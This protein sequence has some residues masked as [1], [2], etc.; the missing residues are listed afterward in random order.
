MITATVDATG[1]VTGVKAGNVT[2]TAT[3][4]ADPSK[5]AAAAVTVNGGPTVVNPS[6][7]IN[8]VLGRWER[9]LLARRGMR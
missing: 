6:I 2:I 1:K 8:S 3:S 7:A 9:T 5:Q 4:T